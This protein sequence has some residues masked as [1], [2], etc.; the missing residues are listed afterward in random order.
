MYNSNVL[1]LAS[2]T[3][4]SGFTNNSALILSNSEPI[5]IHSVRTAPWRTASGVS[6]YTYI[7]CSSSVP[8]TNSHFV[9]PKLGVSYVPSIPAG[10]GASTT[11]FYA[12]DVLNY[13]CSS[14]L[15]AYL[16]D[17]GNVGVSYAIN[18]SYDASTTPANPVNVEVS[19][20]ALT[21]F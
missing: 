11:P 12:V 6:T 9:E 16:K 14:N 18:Y 2:S 21:A 20:I 17:V 15:Y 19:Q 4:N 13:K 5:T 1:T 7:T 10:T 3:S 8:A